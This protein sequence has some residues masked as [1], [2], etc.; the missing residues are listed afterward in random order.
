MLIGVPRET[1]PGEL[2]AALVPQSVK[3]LVDAG[4]TVMVEAGVGSNA[5]FKDSE[6]VE[7]G[8]KV[9]TDRDLILGADIV[10]RVRKPDAAE[11]DK[12]KSG[13]IQISFLDP[14]N[15]KPLVETIAA[16]GVTAISMEMVPRTTK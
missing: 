11:V 13:A 10:L 6:Y 7:A 2:R 14:F 1:W 9:E 8:A 16:R 5:S 4:F 3:K 12:L 15:E